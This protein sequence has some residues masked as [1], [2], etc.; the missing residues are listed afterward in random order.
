M[1]LDLL[2]KLKVIFTENNSLKP[3]RQIDAGIIEIIDTGTGYCADVICVLCPGNDSV[4]ECLLQKFSVQCSTKNS[5]YYWNTT[6]FK[7][8]VK[9]HYN[10]PPNKVT[11]ENSSLPELPVQNKP[12][13]KCENLLEGTIK[14][15]EINSMP[16]EVDDSSI[17]HLDIAQVDVNN[18]VELTSFLFSQFSHQILNIFEAV[19]TN[20]ESMV[21]IVVEIEKKSMKVKVIRTVGNG[22]CLFAA[23]VL[24]LNLV[25]SGTEKHRKMT[26]ELRHKLVTHIKS[27]FER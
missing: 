19:L 26:S 1:T 3:V 16:I 14:D 27:N 11:A 20:G 25:K 24:Q 21:P 23:L 4:E 5:K 10:K 17:L 12:Q 8:H 7:K 9:G 18:E 2:K 15:F 6:N 13:I 22:D